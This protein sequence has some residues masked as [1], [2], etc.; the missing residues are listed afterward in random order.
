MRRY[1]LRQV[2]RH[3]YVLNKAMVVPIFRQVSEAGLS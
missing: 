1:L 3:K 2:S